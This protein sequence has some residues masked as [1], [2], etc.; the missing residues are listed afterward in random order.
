MTLPVC[1][2][3]ALVRPCVCVF[4]RLYG[5]ACVRILFALVRPCVRVYSFRACTALRVCVFF[6]CLYGPACVRVF[7]AFTTACARVLLCACSFRVCFSRLY[8]PACVRVWFVLVR[9]CVRACLFCACTALHVCVFFS[10]CTALLR[11]YTFRVCTALRACI[12]PCVRAYSFCACTALRACVCVLFVFV[13]RVFML[14]FL[15]LRTRV[16]V[17]VPRLCAC[18]FRSCSFC[19]PRAYVFDLRRGAAH[20]HEHFCGV[21]ERRYV[22]TFSLF[23]LF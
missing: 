8:G 15:Y 6:S 12:C 7:C 22:C 5:P 2:R 11:A 9:S 20:V 16:G 23:L 18:S 13:R 4:F 17:F 1:V 10:R 14:F 19:S 3:F 21:H